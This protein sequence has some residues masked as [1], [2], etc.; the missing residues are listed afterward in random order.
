MFSEEKCSIIRH[1]K[2][3]EIFLLV[4]LTLIIKATTKD[5]VN[6]VFTQLKTKGFFSCQISVKCFNVCAIPFTK[7]KHPLYA[8]DILTVTSKLNCD[9]SFTANKTCVGIQGPKNTPSHS[10][11]KKIILLIST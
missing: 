6:S 1:F 8:Q 3:T 5:S 9:H 11:S 7:A 4:S 2:R 10:T